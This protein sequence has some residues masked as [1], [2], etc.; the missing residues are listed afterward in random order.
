MR[1]AA[2]L[3][4][5]LC[6][7]PRPFRLQLP[8]DELDA[9]WSDAMGTTDPMSEPALP[10]P[11]VVAAA[12]AAAAGGHGGQ[13]AALVALVQRRVKRIAERAFWDS[14][15]VGVGGCACVGEALVPQGRAYT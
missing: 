14:V 10:T 8:T 1:L 6:H 2:P 7:A 9:A 5:N 12:A 3:P 13:E 15:Q 4:V 11:E